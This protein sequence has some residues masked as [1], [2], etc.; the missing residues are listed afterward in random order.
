MLELRAVLN[1]VWQW[2]PLLHGQVVSVQL[3]NCSAVAYILR[4]GGT[5]ST[6]LMSL[7]KQLFLADLW[8][9]E[10]CLCYLPG[11]ANIEADALLRVN[12]QV[13]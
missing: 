9:I 7:T 2:A 12:K 8:Q 5:C 3:D 13:T 6:R 11:I 10:L 4:E 1:A